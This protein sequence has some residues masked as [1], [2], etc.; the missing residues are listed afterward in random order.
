MISRTIIFNKLR[1]DGINRMINFKRYNSSLSP[2]M[3]GARSI[4]RALEKYDFKVAFGY[5]GGAVLPLLDAFNF[6]DIKFIMNRDEQCSG[7]SASGYTKSS[8]KTGLTVTTSGPGVTNLV[9]P[10]H[11]ALS[12]GIPFLALTGQVP[13]NAIGTDAFQ[14]CPAVEITKA[15]TKWSYQ[16]KKG[17]KLE[18]VIDKAWEIMHAQRKGPVHIDLP[19]DIMMNEYNNEEN[20][21]CYFGRGK[22]KTKVN[23]KFNSH[24]LHNLIQIA[25]KPVIIAGQ[26]C[27]DC[28]EDLRTFVKNTNI[29]IT[30]TLHAMGSYDERDTKSLHMLGMHGSVYANYAVQNADL[31]IAIGSR[32]D[33]RITGNLN[34]HAVSAHQAFK[35]KKGGLVHVDNSTNQIS[36]VKKIVKPDISIQ[37]H[38]KDFLQI[39][40]KQDYK[41]DNYQNWHKQINEWK[42]KFPFYYHPS[43]NGKPKTQEVIKKIYNYVQ[44]NKINQDMIITTGVGNHQMMAAQFYR[45][46]RPKSIL[47]SGSS[48]TM[49]VGLPFAIGA[50]VANPSK[51][52]VVFDGDGS[53]NMTLNDLG[54]VVQN[55]LP[56]KIVIFNDK[57]QQ[58]VYVWQKLFFEERFIAT[59]NVNPDFVKLAESYGMQAIDCNNSDDVDTTIELMFETNQPILVDFNI[60]PDTCLPL[61][62]PG[63]NLDEMITD[64]S[65][66]VPME[67]LAPS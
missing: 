57:R 38:A 40:N 16:V 14:E 32:L 24:K 1:Y 27:N 5:S 22:F 34:G 58:M 17:D 15:C 30:T 29:P 19:K 55:N 46:S 20:T 23:P 45:W 41:K 65:E 4:I 52:V 60:E 62:A 3:N 49:G 63:K 66:I 7:H 54:T 36:K 33:D 44:K 25:K 37:A 21:N 42:L 18:E 31:I 51:K 6:S 61:V 9:T 43:E 59:D 48:G 10:L 35:E 56:I 39:M 26:G 47:T 12:D 53:F 67:G 50:Q 11:D 13:T 64:Y 2:N 8:G 28:A